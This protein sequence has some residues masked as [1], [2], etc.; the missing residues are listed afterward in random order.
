[1]DVD[2][3]ALS[4]SRARSN[5]LANQKASSV[6]IRSRH[7]TQTGPVVGLRF[8]VAMRFK[9]ASLRQ[10]FSECAH[11]CRSFPQTG[12]LLGHQQVFWGKSTEFVPGRG[13]TLLP[14]PA[15]GQLAP[16]VPGS[17]R[18]RIDASQAG[19]RSCSLLP[20]S[21]SFYPAPSHPRRRGRSAPRPSGP[22][23]PM[24][25]RPGRVPTPPSR[26]SIRARGGPRL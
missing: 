18:R 8:L 14:G 19:D 6:Q 3:S 4:L 11:I 5:R 10:N 25:A 2:S 24:R 26:G 22:L 7:M 1:M 13:G 17:I 12:T 9:V 15:W 20:G 21:R 23:P 16:T